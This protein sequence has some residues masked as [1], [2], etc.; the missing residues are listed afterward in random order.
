MLTI[1]VSSTLPYELVIVILP[2]KL[3]TT[4]QLS[5]LTITIVLSLSRRGDDRTS[6][7]SAIGFLRR[8]RKDALVAMRI[9][10]YSLRPVAIYKAI[11]SSCCS[12][13]RPRDSIGPLGS[14][15]LVFFVRFLSVSLR[16]LPIT[17]STFVLRASRKLRRS[18]LVLNQ[19]ELTMSLRVLSLQMAN[20]LHL[21]ELRLPN[22]RARRYYYS[23]SSKQSDSI[24]IVLACNRTILE[25]ASQ[26]QSTI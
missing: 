16:Y 18:L 14:L 21:L 4:S 25:A 10:L 1:C 2:Y 11:R 6:T 8:R 3:Q 19:F 17:S 26:S 7:I 15:T 23:I 20:E 13:G 5:S 9:R 12:A 24:G 22:S